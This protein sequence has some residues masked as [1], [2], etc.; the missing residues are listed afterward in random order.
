MKPRWKMSRKMAGWS[1]VVLGALVVFHYADRGALT[2]RSAPVS[3]PL[4]TMVSGEIVSVSPN[5][6][7]IQL[8][9]AKGQLTTLTR[10]VALTT[11]TEVQYPGKSHQTGRAALSLL[12]EGYRVSVEGQTTGSQIN[13]AMVAVNFPPITGT[14]Q[15][16]AANA[17]TLRVPGTSEPLTISLTSQTVFPGAKDTW[18]SLSRGSTVKVEMVPSQHQG[19][20][21][22]SVT[23]EPKS[24]ATAT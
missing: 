7:A 23:L 16:A 9:N 24:T 18:Q 12:R 19:L 2:G 5:T 13:A 6:M 22:L 10:T 4:Q 21:A 8:V 1:M 11:R 20:K 14:V 15:Q 17:L 3:T